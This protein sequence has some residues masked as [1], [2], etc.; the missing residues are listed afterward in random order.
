MSKTKQGRIS[1]AQRPAAKKIISSTEVF[2]TNFDIP[3]DVKKELESQGLEGRWLSAKRVYENNGYH[4]SG[5]QVY[6]RDPSAILDGAFKAFGDPDGL[7]RRGDTI[8]GVKTKEM[9]EKHRSYLR[10]QADAQSMAN[11]KKRHVEELR[12]IAREANEDVNIEQDF[13]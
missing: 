3:E 4:K 9:A 8:L 2:G 11:V 13:D 6:R 12:N 7:V 1:S 5:W 10:Q